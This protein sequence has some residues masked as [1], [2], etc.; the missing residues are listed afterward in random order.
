M[1]NLADE[2]GRAAWHA[3]RPDAEEPDVHLTEEDLSSTERRY[4]PPPF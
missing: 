4:G 3:E 2:E 1:S